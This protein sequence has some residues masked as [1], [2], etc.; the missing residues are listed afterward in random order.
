MIDWHHWHQYFH[1][2]FHQVGCQCYQ[3]L[4][5][6]RQPCWTGTL[7]T[8]LNA[9]WISVVQRK[10]GNSGGIPQDPTGLGQAECLETWVDTLQLG[11][12]KMT[13]V[14]RQRNPRARG[15]GLKVRIERLKDQCLGK[16][17]CRCSLWPPTVLNHNHWTSRCNC[18]KSD[19]WKWTDFRSVCV[20]GVLPKP[21]W[22]LAL[23]ERDTTIFWLYKCLKKDFG[24][25]CH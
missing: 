19:V 16:G 12:S 13:G 18:V 25:R 7:E 23:F 6:P 1:C 5:R 20:Y 11:G 24:D 9:Q 22:I 17:L 21:N 3:L 15:R 14:A 2:Y 10:R 8:K 4:A